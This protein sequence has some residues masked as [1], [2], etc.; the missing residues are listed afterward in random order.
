MAKS[1]P[2]PWH[3]KPALGRIGRDVA[4]GSISTTEAEYLIGVMLQPCPQERRGA[5]ADAM[6][7]IVKFGAKREDHDRSMA[8]GEVMMAIKPLFIRQR[9]GEE[10]RDA[11][12]AANK[13]W[14]RDPFGPGVLREDELIRLV[15]E[16][17]LVHQHYQRRKKRCA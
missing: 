17:W 7:E 1:W 6:L 15:R 11:A 2:W 10:V 13:R 5:E 9:P 16:E 12:I 3:Y 14:Q 8:E 4:R